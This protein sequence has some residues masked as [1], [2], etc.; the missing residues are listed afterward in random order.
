MKF[1]TKNVAV[2]SMALVMTLG[3]WAFAQEPSGPPAG[4]DQGPPP[5]MMPPPEGRSPQMGPHAGG[6]WWKDPQLRQKLQLSDEQVQKIEKI[7][8]DQHLQEIDLRADVEKQDVLL[9]TLMESDAPDKSQALAQ[10]DRLSEARARLERSRV[11]MFLS[12]QQ[13][14]TPEQAKKLRSLPPLAGAP[15]PGAE[16]PEG[17][18][19]P[20]PGGPTQ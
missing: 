19:P 5:E 9:R 18:P 8:R 7:A 12:I 15:G 13:V 11:E 10:V 2:A 6:P 4:P 16:P 3:G 17:A 20:P 14:L 1:P